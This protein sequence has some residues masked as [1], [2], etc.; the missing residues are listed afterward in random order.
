MGCI[1][2]SSRQ[3]KVY[4]SSQHFDGPEDLNFVQYST[5]KIFGDSET[6]IDLIP[7]EGQIY[8]SGLE[9]LFSVSFREGS[10]YQG[11]NFFISPY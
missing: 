2:L 10:V 4:R 8:F 3:H 7:V 11:H 5:K 1:W 6:Y 9:G